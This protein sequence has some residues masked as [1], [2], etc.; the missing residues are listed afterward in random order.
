MWRPAEII[1][2]RGVQDDAVTRYILEQCPGVPARIVESGR[3][4][5]VVAASALLGDLKARPDTGLLDIVR[6]GKKVLYI[7]PSGPGTVDRFLMPDH[8]FQCPDFDRLKLAAN[9]CFY[10]CDWC[11]LK[12]TYRAAFPFITVYADYD[13]IKERIAARLAK[14]G[15]IVFFNSGELADSLAMEH[16]TRA[17]RAFVPWFG[18]TANGYLFMLTKSDNVDGLLDL[19]HNRHTV[20]AWSLNNAEVSR[21]YE[22]GAPPLHRRLSAA[23]R[24]QAAGYPI[25]LRIDPILPFD[26]WQAAYRQTVDQIFDQVRPERITLGTL[27]FEKQFYQMRHSIFATGRALLPLVERMTPMFEPRT[28]TVGG[29]VRTSVGKYSFP[30][31]T[32]VA[33]FDFLVGAIRRHS[34]CPIALCKESADVWRRT[35]L[36]LTKNGCVCQY[37][38]V[39]METGV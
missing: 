15:E 14:T 23:A 4:A 27:R 11:Y 33:L 34:D 26:G 5:A 36:D 1:I 29:K 6:A 9:G 25:R 16:L 17:G 38:F 2:H 8:R 10:Q 24:A 31:E 39:N 13:R 35:G 20:L 32:R 12:L 28:E 30:E 22:I 37:G 21:R 19:A 18:R 7:S 3:A